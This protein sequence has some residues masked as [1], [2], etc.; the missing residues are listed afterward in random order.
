MA[1]AVRVARAT[2]GRSKV[3]ICGYHGWHDWYL[4][5][6]LGDSDQLKGHLLPGL[7]PLGVPDCLRGSAGTF[8]YNR[9]DEF[10]RLVAASGDDLAAVVMEPCRYDLPENDFLEKVRDLAHA[11]GALLIFDEIT[12]GWRL[13][14]GGAHLKLG[15]NPDI[16]VFAKA[17]GNGHPIGAV[18][19]TPEAMRG[20]Y[21]SFI[22]ST[23]WTERTG[24]AA[25]LAVLKKMKAVD[26]PAH[27]A[28]IGEKF[29]TVIAENAA[30][31]DVKVVV[32]KG[33]PCLAHF[34]FDYPNANAVRTLYTRLML[35]KGFL[36]AAAIYPTLAHNDAIM[37]RFS[38][39]VDETFG[40]LA[41]LIRADAVAK[42]LNGVEAKTGFKRLN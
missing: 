36:A 10:E 21:D 24:P 2:T 20:A 34:A 39:A 42:A 9:F 7:N 18:I 41:E 31:R 38:A 22:S 15:V 11:R 27:V 29:K 25:A 28:R 40:R 12:I 13:A 19:G 33:F 6:N 17:L 14:R 1:I 3:A 23:Y 37:A 35:D 4:A 26:V 32:D 30:K 16:A 5:A 8:N